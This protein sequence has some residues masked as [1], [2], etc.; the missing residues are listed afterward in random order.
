VSVVLTY[1]SDAISGSVA[2]LDEEADE[3]GCDMMDDEEG[4]VVAVPLVLL[5][6]CWCINSD[7]DDAFDMVPDRNENDVMDEASCVLISEMVLPR[8]QC[9]FHACCQYVYD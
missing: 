3:I 4:V 9:I 8:G 5:L 2:T 1:V 6:P 7:G